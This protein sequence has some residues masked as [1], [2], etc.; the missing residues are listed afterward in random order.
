[1]RLHRAK[2]MKNREA[3]VETSLRSGWYGEAFF[4]ARQDPDWLDSD[5]TLW[6]ENGSAEGVGV[7]AF[8]TDEIPPITP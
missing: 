7:E 3:I 5:L 8:D 4:L 6:K 1:M 2:R